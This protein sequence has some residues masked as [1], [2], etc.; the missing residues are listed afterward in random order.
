MSKLIMMYGLPGSG[1]SRRALALAEEGYTRVNKDSIREMLGMGVTAFP[2]KRETTV[3]KIRDS[4]I[5]TALEQGQNVVVDDTNLNPRHKARLEQLAREHGAEF[6]VFDLTDVSVATCIERD[7]NREKH[8]GESVIRRMHQQW[9]YKPAID[10]FQ[11]GFNKTVI[12][13]VDGTV[14]RHNGRSPY[15]FTKVSEDTPIQ[16][17]VELVWSLLEAR[18]SVVFMSG[19]DESC[20][21][22]TELW[23]DEHITGNF[24][25]FMRPEGDTRPDSVVKK[26]L[27]EKHL[28][29]RNV[30]LVIDDRQQ[31]VD[32]WRQELGLP[33]LQV[34][35]GDF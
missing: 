14:A 25:L 2:P 12:V 22:D 7:R 31:V 5:K 27:F 17:V 3:I 28:S 9:L 30:L 19:R 32:M 26:E 16:T 10:S 8:V 33:T 21:K 18:H 4:I 1:K 20:R 23:I 15:D 24:E 34:E 29:D 35:Y 11:S 6:E 13:D